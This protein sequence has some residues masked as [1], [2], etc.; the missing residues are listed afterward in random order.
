MSMDD[1]N[2]LLVEEL[3]D[4]YSA[5][6]QLTKALPK[7]AKKA[8]NQT[9]KDAFTTHLEETQEQIARLEQIAEMMQAR[10]TGKVCKA[11]QGLIE[12]GKEILEEDGHESVIDA[13]L[14]GAAQRIEHYE[15]AA[16]GT[17]RAI[18]EK[19]GEDKVAKILQTTLDEEG[20]TD[21]K[22][23]AISE[24]EVLESANSAGEEERDDEDEAEEEEMPASRGK[25]KSKSTRAR[26]R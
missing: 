20:E 15:I 19:L 1:L 22:L 13:A 11:M 18:A 7:M 17:A 9:L 3:K 26:S 16:Y 14:I 10:L 12:E 2:G 21:K 5:E 24:D 25:S 8:S 4:L 6:K 23:T